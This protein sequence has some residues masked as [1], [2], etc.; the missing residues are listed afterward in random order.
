MKLQTTIMGIALVGLLVLSSGCA[1]KKELEEVRDIA[2][3]ADL[4]AQTAVACC[5]IEQ[6]RVSRM[7]EKLMR[8]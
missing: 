8:K 6:D 2:E 7:Y 4:M 3:Q 1:T 5:Q